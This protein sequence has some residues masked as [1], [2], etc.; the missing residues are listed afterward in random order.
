MSHTDNNKSAGSS[1]DRARKELFAA[2]KHSFRTPMQ[3]LLVFALILWGITV[4]QEEFLTAEEGFG[5]ALGIIGGSMMLLLLLYP[6]RKK[7]KVG[8]YMGSVPGWFK[9]HMFCGV[10][11]PIA[12]LYHSN[13]SMGSLNS[14]VAMLCMITVASS[15]LFG[16]YFYSKIHYGLY[17]RKASVN[18]LRQIIDSE[19]H[20]LAALYKLMPEMVNTLKSYH[21]ESSKTLGV[22]DSLKR[23]FVFGFKLRYL[24]LVLPFK[25]R[26]KL[27]SYADKAGWSKKQTNHNFKELKGHFRAFINAVLQTCEYSI[28]E[29]LFAL[30]HVLHYPL[31]L[32][33]VISGVVHVFAVHMY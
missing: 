28:F 11:G 22:T 21:L 29:R 7:M 30:W 12:I 2:E 6:V 8:R 16:R 27:D 25:L 17:G 20:Q 10:F 5:Y 26:K 9:F 24:S 13:Y 4:K 33:L 19:E 23:L 31:F 3:V 15:G 1:L 32:M 18:E 14:S